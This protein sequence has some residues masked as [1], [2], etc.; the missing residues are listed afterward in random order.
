MNDI[1]QPDQAEEV[2]AEVVSPSVPAEVEEDNWKHVSEVIPKPIA[3]L[4]PYVALIERVVLDPS[5]DISKLEKMLEMKERMDA[6]VSRRAFDQAIAAAKA[7]I[8]P[9]IR[10]GT[11]DYEIKGG[12]RT[13]F[14]HETLDGIAKVVDPI[15]SEF[16]LSYRFRSEQKDG[17]V[18]VTCI[19][20]HR[21]GH[22]EETTLQ[23]AP[24]S[25]GSKNGY[26]AVGSAVTYLQ[27][28]T[29][30]LALGLSAAKDDD[31]KAATAPTPISGEQFIK[32]RDLIGLIGIDE[33]VILDAERITALEELPQKRFDYV[34]GQLEVTAKKN[35]MTL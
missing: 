26:Q 14:R 12:G 3:Q 19:V 22:S 33:K 28:Y 1:S 34:K 25:S 31:A 21:D 10:T 13:F 23:G 29:L 15:L 27:R 35:G 6:Q 30:K 18:H 9:I 17:Q 24:D 20:A 16:G 4:D 7:K 2:D 8:P 5:A 32:L 11:V